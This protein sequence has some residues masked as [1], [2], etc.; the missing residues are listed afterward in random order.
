MAC[1]D[2]KYIV[3]FDYD[4][5]RGLPARLGGTAANDLILTQGGRAWGRAGD[6]FIVDGDAAVI[7]PALR[8]HVPAD[9]VEYGREAYDSRLS[10]GAGDDVIIAGD[11]YDTVFAGPGDDYIAGD[12]VEL[13]DTG[14][15]VRLPPPDYRFIEERDR[16]SV[17]ECSDG[18]GVW[19][20]QY[21]DKLYGGPG[22]DAILGGP[23]SD[24][25]QGGPGY[26]VLLGGEGRDVLVPGKG[27]EPAEE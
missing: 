24:H 1:V 22:Q 2:K 18:D 19:K 16:I 26:D 13:H 23:G 27:G 25:L 5:W 9:P 12:A 7:N 6:D 4:L 21:R 10:G 11:G 3:V 15:Q 8:R 20:G 17:A 14:S